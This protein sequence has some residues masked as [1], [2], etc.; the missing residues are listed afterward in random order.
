MSRWTHPDEL[1]PEDV[2]ARKAHDCAAIATHVHLLALGVRDT[3]G[4]ILELGAGHYSTPL[5]S[6]HSRS[7]VVITLESN[8]AFIDALSYLA[9]IGQLSGGRD[10]SGHYIGR[11]T[12]WASDIDKLIREEGPF[13]LAFIDHWPPEER[14]RAAERLRRHAAVIVMHDGEEPDIRAIAKTFT[15]QHWHTERFPFTV[16]LSDIAALPAWG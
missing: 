2:E 7:R 8:Q 1:K 6:A 13:G 10:N 11:T 3:R 16:A 4:T 12:D 5:L 15:Y 14:C 9:T